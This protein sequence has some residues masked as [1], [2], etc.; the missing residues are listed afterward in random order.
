MTMEEI[1]RQALQY[2]VLVLM[3]LITWNVKEII[4]EVKS[5][6]TVTDSHELNLAK[7]NERLGFHRERI[8]N[9]EGDSHAR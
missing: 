9:L 6:R 8:E 4:T 3:G 1:F 2:G 5:L 7:V